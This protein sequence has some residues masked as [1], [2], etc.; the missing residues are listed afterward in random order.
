M[1]NGRVFHLDWRLRAIIQSQDGSGWIEQSCQSGWDLDANA[2][3]RKPHRI[4][5]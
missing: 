4:I 5:N 3:R 1:P 2:R